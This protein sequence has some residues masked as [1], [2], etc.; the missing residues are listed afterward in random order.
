MLR[1]HEAV[2]RQGGYPVYLMYVDE[3]GDTGLV[4]SPTRYFV[5]AGLV[6]HESAWAATLRSLIGYRRYL[7]TR[8]GVKIRDELHASVLLSKPGHLGARL[9][10][11]ERLAILRTFADHVGSLRDVSLVVV[12][13]DKS[14]KRVGYDVF[15]NAWRALIQRFENTMCHANFPGAYA[16]DNGLILPDLTDTGRL[17]KLLRRMRYY[18]PVPN[19]P[20]YGSGGYNAPVTRVVEDP[21]FKDS[22]HS[23]FIQ[24]A[25]L[26]AYLVYQHLSPSKYMRRKG[27]HAY[28]HRLSNV[29]CTQASRSHQ[30]GFVRL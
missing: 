12:L 13:V 17:T 27:G 19:R 26:A 30:Y 11:H 14:T 24:A 4:G 28:F 18:N 20:W 29:Y 15:E 22:K 7:R 25:D 8:F 21:Y 5:L 2:P 6:V 9:K 23:Y 3:S 1:A 16:A 10:K